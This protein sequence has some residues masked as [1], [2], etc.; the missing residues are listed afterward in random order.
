MQIFFKAWQLSIKEQLLVKDVDVKINDAIKSQGEVISKA[1]TN[2]VLVVGTRVGVR[3]VKRLDHRT[4]LNAEQSEA[5][6]EL[7][8]DVV[9]EEY[10]QYKKDLLNNVK[11]TPDNVENSPVKTD[12]Q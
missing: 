6:S 4:V 5:M 8:S 7:I 2:A 3:I 11:Q 9:Y 10:D 1:I 12:K